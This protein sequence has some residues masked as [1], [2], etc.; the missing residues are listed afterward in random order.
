MSA[1]AT[2]FLTGSTIRANPFNRPYPCKRVG[3]SSVPKKSICADK[4]RASSFEASSLTSGQLQ[5]DSLDVHGNLHTDRLIVGSVPDGRYSPVDD[6]AL[7]VHGDVVVHGE[8][9]SLTIEGALALCTGAF[10]APARLCASKEGRCTPLVLDIAYD[11]PTSDCARLT[12][13]PPST[14]AKRGNGTTAEIKYVHALTHCPDQSLLGW[15]ETRVL[16]VCGEKQ[17]VLQTLS[18]SPLTGWSNSGIFQR[19]GEVD[20]GWN[21]WVD[22]QATPCT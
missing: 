22:L 10:E 14:Y 20:M 9:A 18:T 2:A 3:S 19:T 15:L 5:T 6:E 4:V 7:V 8:C 11:D 21:P 12:S 16:P 1:I 17:L 13:H